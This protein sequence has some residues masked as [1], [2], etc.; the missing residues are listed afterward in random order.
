MRVTP[1]PVW[2]YLFPDSPRLEKSSPVHSS[3]DINKDHNRKRQ[4]Q[5]ESGNGFNR[6]LCKNFCFNKKSAY[7]NINNK[8]SDL[9][10]QNPESIHPVTTW[11]IQLCRYSVIYIFLFSFYSRFLRQ[12]N[13]T[14]IPAVP[15]AVKYSDASIGVFDPRGSLQMD[16]QACPLGSLSAEI[17][18]LFYFS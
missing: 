18:V 1:A 7:Y 17:K 3:C 12:K 13:K 4:F 16:M 5:Y 9:F 2:N 6:D 10:Q 14:S 15:A 8:K 11:Q